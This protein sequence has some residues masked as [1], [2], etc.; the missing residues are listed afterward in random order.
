MTRSTIRVE[1]L[2]V[3]CLI[4]CLDP[5]RRKAQEIRIDLRLSLDA[6]PAADADDLSRTRDYAA[7]A[8][9]VTFI[10]R[11]GRFQLLET[12]SRFLLRYL[13]LPL[14]D[15]DPR[16]PVL[17]AAVAITKF[18]A[19]PGDARARVEIEA[20]SPPTYRQERQPWGTVDIIDECRRLGLYRLNLAANACIPNHLHRR[21]REAEMVLTHGIVGWRDGDAERPLTPGDEAA[22]RREQSHGYRNT[23]GVWGSL[24]CLDSPP[25]DPADE[26]QTPRVVVAAT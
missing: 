9:E 2:R 1:D 20:N 4:G 19:L 8:R 22:W 26:V 5:E 18:G 12:A 21:M 3:D 15:D 25:F 14:L 7:L 11:E 24:L 16:P 17:S 6:T 13:M 10:L 23:R